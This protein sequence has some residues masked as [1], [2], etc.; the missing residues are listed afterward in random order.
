MKEAAMGWLFTEGA[1]RDDVI[2]DRIQSWSNEEFSTTVIAHCVRDDVLWSIREVTYKES[3]KVKRYIFCDLL[4][5]HSDQHYNGWGYKSMDEGM[6]PY[7][8]SCPKDYLNRVPEVACAQWREGV[9]KR[10]RLAHQTLA[11]G[12]CISLV[13]FKIPHVDI[14]CL[15]PLRGAYGGVVYSLKRNF[16]GEKLG[17]TSVAE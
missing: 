12:D 3:S 9:L 13:G 10:H 2:C 6:H 8:Y 7:C 1:T 11:I 5:K 17:C 15:K 14:T 16:L 4:E